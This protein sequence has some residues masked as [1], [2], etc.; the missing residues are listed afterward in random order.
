MKKFFIKLFTV[1]ILLSIFIFVYEKY[2]SCKSLKT[3]EIKITTNLITDN[4]N[5]LKI[6]HISDLYYYNKDFLKE[7]IEEVNLI[8]PDILVFTGDLLKH[9]LNEE[10]TNELINLFNT[11]NVKNKYIIKGDN[12]NFDNWEDI[13]T[14]SNFINLNNKSELIFNNSNIPIIISGIDTSTDIN[15]ASNNINEY[16]DNLEVKP[17]YS[18][19][20]M[21]EPDYIDNIDLANYNLILAGHSLGGINIP[22]IGR[23]NLPDKAKK[24]SYGEYKVNDSL[25]YVSNGVGSNGNE[26]RLFNNPSI[27]FYRI[28]K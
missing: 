22:I 24:Y 20:L 13:I 16:I 23:V 27:N 9:E 18:I 1:L 3:N 26:F 4:F 12:D 14:K 10:Q 11:I 17:C 25:L 7:I 5:G 28:V 15:E 21:H 8:N 6:V 2:I 19:L